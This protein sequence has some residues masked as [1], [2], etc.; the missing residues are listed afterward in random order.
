[1]ASITETVSR[2][3]GRRKP[4]YKSLIFGVFVAFAGAQ[5]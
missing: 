4:I 5:P 2:P 3:T 1:M